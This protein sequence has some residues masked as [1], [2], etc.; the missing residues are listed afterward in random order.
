[1]KAL[2]LADRALADSLQPLLEEEGVQIDAT[3]R[4]ARADFQVKTE[5]YDVVLIDRD[6]LGSLGYEELL[7]WR[8]DGLKAHVLVLLPPDAD[9]FD[10][11]DALDAGADAYLLHP[12]CV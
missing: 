11:I 12:L 5:A 4:F 2:F 1:M 6:R 9:S 3:Q 8:R 10:R 7:R